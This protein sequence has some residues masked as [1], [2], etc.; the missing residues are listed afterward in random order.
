MSVRAADDTSIVIQGDNGAPWQ[1]SHPPSTCPRFGS[2]GIPRQGLASG[3]HFF[4]DQPDRRPVPW[5]RLTYHHVTSMARPHASAGCRRGWSG[6]T[7]GEELMMGQPR[8][9]APAESVDANAGQ[10]T[11]IDRVEG[12]F[13]EAVAS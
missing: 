2:C 9:V 11:C 4:Q 6:R 13:V 10:G 3:T 7:E 1:L 8:G 5:L 12:D